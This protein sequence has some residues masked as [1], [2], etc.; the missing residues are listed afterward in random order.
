MSRGNTARQ[1]IPVCSRTYVV[2]PGDFCDGISAAQNASTYVLVWFFRTLTWCFPDTNWLQRTLGSLMLTAPTY[3]LERWICLQA[4]NSCRNIDPIY[5]QTICLGL[6]GEDCTTV[7]VVASGDGC[8]TISEAAGI[9]TSTLLSDNPN[10]NSACTNIYVG[11]VRIV[12]L[13]LSIV[14]LCGILGIVYCCFH[15]INPDWPKGELCVILAILWD[16]I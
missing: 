14:W 5:R 9:S 6:V 4:C 2:Q 16:A 10:V 8:D 3:S 11:E 13:E 15:L 12:L 1:D 7:H